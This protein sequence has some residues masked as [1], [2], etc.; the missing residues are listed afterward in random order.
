MNK[1][2][3]CAIAIV[4]AFVI[5]IL[6]AN[7]VVDAAGGWKE[8]L[9]LHEEDSSAHHDVPEAQ[10]YEVSGVSVIPGSNNPAERGNEVQLRCLDGDRLISTGFPFTMTAEPIADIIADGLTIGGAPNQDIKE[11]PVSA[12]SASKLIGYDVTPN[13]DQLQQPDRLYDITVITSIMCFSPS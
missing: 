7:P 11:F 3:I 10:V 13:R 9:V 1:L 8:A 4:G 6:S 12:I 2:G 5:G